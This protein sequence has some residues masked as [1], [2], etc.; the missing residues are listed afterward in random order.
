MFEVS[1]E[2]AMK[3]FLGKI[4]NYSRMIKQQEIAAVKAGALLF[5]N[6]WKRNIQLGVI[7]YPKEKKRK[8]KDGTYYKTRHGWKPSTGTYARS[9]HT[10]V[11]SDYP[12]VVRVGSDLNNPPYPFFLEYGT[13]YIT[14]RLWATKAFE[15]TEFAVY[16][17]IRRI[18]MNMGLV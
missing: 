8:R 17:E 14:P 16:E 11:I 5:Q 18:M 12:A 9:V 7:K 6:E 2:N 15:Q 1:G 13:K 4:E 10:K 3:N